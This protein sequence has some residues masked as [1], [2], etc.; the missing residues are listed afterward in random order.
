MEKYG[1]LA[2]HARRRIP[3]KNHARKIRVSKRRGG[4]GTCKRFD[5]LLQPRSGARVLARVADSLGVRE[6][7][8]RDLGGGRYA[9]NLGRFPQGDYELQV[10]ARADDGDL[11]TGT[12][13]FTVGRYSLEY[14]T[15]RMRAELLGDIATRSG[16]QYVR[17]DNLKA[18]LD[19]LVL[20]PEP[21]VSHHRARL[22]GHEWPL[23]VLLGL[24]AFE[25]T[26]RRRL[27]ML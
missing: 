27:G 21:V 16:G 14:E 1:A 18:A 4:R 23:F 12:G 13:R 22:W 25:W 15:V 3:H 7:V 19:S 26:I 24:L 11:G 2:G 8:L 6:I 17:P 10:Q 20:A 9:G 5:H